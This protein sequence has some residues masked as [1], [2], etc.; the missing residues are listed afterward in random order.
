MAFVQFFVAQPWRKLEN[1]PDFVEAHIVLI[2]SF[3]PFS[4]D[5]VMVEFERAGVPGPHFRRWVVAPTVSF[6]YR[7][8][9]CESFRPLFT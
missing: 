2:T 3:D 8:Y 5:D 6:L 9:D 1:V 7:S 4:Y